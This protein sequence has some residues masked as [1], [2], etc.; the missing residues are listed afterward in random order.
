MTNSQAHTDPT[1]G[2][3]RRPPSI[4]AIAALRPFRSTGPHQAGVRGGT[5]VSPVPR[6]LPLSEWL[7]CRRLLSG[8]TYYVSPGGSDV[9]AG[10]TDGSAWKTLQRAA[11][12]V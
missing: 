4:A 1:P 10:T 5:A 9:A 7:E 11:N 12:A 2:A 6:P 8:S 3:S